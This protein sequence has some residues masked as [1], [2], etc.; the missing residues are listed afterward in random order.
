MNDEYAE[1][2]VS[3]D[4]ELIFKNLT[5][6]ERIK[7]S[8][9][10]GVDPF[11]RDKLE[12]D[13]K[14]NWDLFYKRN[15]DRF[16]KRRY[17]TRREFYEL[18]DCDVTTKPENSSIDVE[19]NGG[20]HVRYLFEVGCGCGD[21]ALPLIDNQ[22]DDQDCSDLSQ[23]QLP[24]D[25]FIYCCD[26]SDK[27]IDLLKSNETYRRHESKKIKAFVGNITTNNVDE[28]LDRLDG[29]KMD[30]VSLVFV[31]SALDPNNMERALQNLSTTMKPQGLVFFRDYAH[32]DKAMLRFN[33]KSKIRDRFYVR[34][35]GTRAYFFTKQELV[36]LFEQANF[37]CNTIEY[38][39]RETVNNATNSAYSRIFLQAKF[40]RK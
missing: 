34:Q 6:E 16:F 35:D 38:V 3:G 26:I 36:D 7:L 19:T 1:A 17:W 24:Q 18:L 20:K 28:I 39:R 14:K 9:R 22:P 32:Y 37:S 15:G 5:V 40:R 30:F 21:F 4:D 12:K 10:P 31:L 27:A 33:E 29:H 23:V 8:C 13:A 2:L 25:L 11:Q